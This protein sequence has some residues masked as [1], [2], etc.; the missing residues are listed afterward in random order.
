MLRPSLTDDEA[1]LLVEAL[2][3]YAE[4]AREAR[5]KGQ[6]P[7]WSTRSWMDVEDAAR[8]LR[9]KLLKLSQKPARAAKV[10]HNPTEA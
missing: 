2:E 8:D 5:R 4:K 10:D 7:T 1:Q 6:L 3:G 9:D